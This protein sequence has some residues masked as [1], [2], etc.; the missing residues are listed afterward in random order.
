MQLNDNVVYL[1]RGS[2][3]TL[4]DSDGDGPMDPWQTSVESRLGEL[5]ADVS[6]LRDDVNRRFDRMSDKIDHHLYMVGAGFI[7]L[8]GLMAKGFH[9]L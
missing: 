1:R 9:W 4:S 2:L 5:H 6:G 3:S 7:A 8:A